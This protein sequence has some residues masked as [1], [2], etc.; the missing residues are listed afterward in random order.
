MNSKT[1]FTVLLF[2]VLFYS[3]FGYEYPTSPYGH[4]IKWRASSL[5]VT[6]YIDID[7]TPDCTGEFLAIS[8]AYQA[9]EDASGMDWTNGGANNYSPSDWGVNNGVNINVWCESNWTGI[10]GSGSGTIAICKYW[11][12][13]TPSEAYLLDTDIIY[14]GQNYT[15]SSTGEAGKMDVQNIA[16]HETGHSLV[17][18][19][20]YGSGDT[21]KT[22]YGYCNLGETK[23]RTLEPDDIDG[24]RF[25]YPTPTTTPVPP[26]VHYYFEGDSDGWNFTGLA[27][28]SYDA[29]FAAATSS[30]DGH[31]LGIVFDN[32]TNRFG[33][34][35][36]GVAGAI[37]YE[38]GK[39]YKFA[40]R[41]S[42]SQATPT[43]V[44]VIRFRI[45]ALDNSFALEMVQT[46]NDGAASPPTA[47]TRTYNQYL[48]P[49]S[50]SSIIPTFDVYDADNAEAGIVYLDG[51]EISKFDVPGSGWTTVS[52]PPFNTGWHLANNIGPYTAASTAGQSASYLSL[53]FT[54]ATDRGFAYWYSDPISWTP[55]RLYRAVFTL[56][57][58]DGPNTVLGAVAAGSL[59]FNWFL[60]YK[61]YGATVP[62]AGGTNYPLYFETATGS[63]FFL[64]FEGI[65]MENT[66][67]GTNSLTAVNLQWNNIP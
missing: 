57:S 32:A 51:L 58:N 66:R 44:P 31:R 12:A 65:D 33:W 14:N 41:C 59:D 22:M 29:Q 1:V 64:D 35:T 42:T 21:E 54:T 24:A 56:S 38:A 18:S 2:G 37:P 7:G 3:S 50:P 9:W 34:W 43:L 53:G 6:Y 4:P 36:A 5:P 11:Y 47:G 28:N 61:Y 63:Q 23:K 67:G 39:L 26:I 55:G 17:L 27:I 52:S 16:T 8:R 60:R 30:Y 25:L 62:G 46:S 10:T 15:W 49:I 19:D 13:Y 40:W 20:L 45:N 48:M